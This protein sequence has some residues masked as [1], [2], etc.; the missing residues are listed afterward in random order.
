MNY[1]GVFDIATGFSATCKV[2]K[3]K[4]VSWSWFVGILQ[5]VTRTNETYTQFIAAKKEEQIAIKDVGGYVGGK[6]I[7]G[8]RTQ[9]TVSH[10]QLVSLDIDYAH[11]S[12]WWDFTML[13][14]VAAVLHSTHKHSPE[15][16]KYRLIFPLS[17]EVSPEEYEAIARRMAGNLNI[18]LF[19]ATTFQVHRLMFW[20]SASVDAEFVFEMQDGPWLDADAI[21]DTYDD[22]RDTSEWPVAKAQNAAIARSVK[23]Q[24]DPLSKSG[25][26]GLFCRTY[27]IEEAIE[28]FLPDIY[29]RTSSERYSFV[30]GT[31]AG[32]LVIY[33]NK[34]AYSHH[35]TDPCCMRL[36]NSFD[37]VRI[38][39]FGKLD[40]N[41]DKADNTQ[42][43]YRKMEEFASH[44]KETKLKIAEEKFAE[45]RLEFD[46]PIEKADMLWTSE[47]D[48][49]T[50][51]VYESSA[52]NINTI[53]RNDVM[54]K[55]AFKLNMFDNKRY[56]VKDLPWRNIKSSEPL[57]DVDYS[58]IRNYIESVYDIAAISK[59]DDSVALEFER[60]SFHPIRDYITSLEWDGK[61]R[62]DTLLIDYFGAEDNQY[63]RAAIR[64]SLTGAIARVFNPGVKFDLVLTLVGD[65]GTGKSTFVHKLGKAWFSDTFVTVQGKEAFEQV[66]GAWIIE[67]AELSGLRKAE[68]ET[69]KQFISKCEDTFRPA[70]GRVIETYKRQC[71]FF[72]TTNNKD[73]LR[74]PS[75]NRRFMP[76]SIDTQSATHSVFDD[77]DE[78]EVD[79]VWA[80]AY[81]L[82]LDGELLFFTQD[83]EEIAKQEQ[84]K[85]TEVDERRGIIDEYINMLLPEDWE[86]YDLDKRRDWIANRR[87]GG[88][89]RRSHVCI[90][91]IWCECLGKEKTDM[92]RYNTRDINEIMRSIRDW[93]FVNS[94]KVFTHF[95]KQKY[96]ARKQY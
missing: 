61:N 47:L 79:M 13:Y 31:T 74:D 62:I 32:G 65:Q 73:F 18:E 48:V 89:N 12:L 8:K 24:E 93:E 6:L 20:P 4:Q 91:E 11:D 34:F 90:A 80:E 84:T 46:T 21:L 30:G 50:R 96:Y 38:H 29:M 26:V 25:I 75:G 23:A 19:D 77:F 36:C 87:D 9:E 14:D 49:N 68:V 10:R 86:A 45:A 53:L 85:H 55:E 22:W 41:K 3:N 44:D 94:T 63:T 5:E 72:G 76:I 69:I 58:G 92:S 56:V 51:G 57:R 42:A 66:Q 28:A 82:Y 17:R 71:V 33:D 88:V 70:Y 54:L 67:I 2:W 35:S 37:L 64:K 95:G 81:K 7:N 27:G 39:K 40:K 78:H 15:T 60:R 16:P 43:S 1:D 52:T 59:I 83:E